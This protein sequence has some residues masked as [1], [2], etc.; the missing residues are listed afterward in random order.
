MY[1]AYRICLF[2]FLFSSPLDLLLTGKGG[3]GG[4]RVTAR[5]TVPGA[6]SVPANE[7]PEA[8]VEAAARGAVDTA[9]DDV[10]LEVDA[11][12]ASAAVKST[13][14]AVPK[15]VNPVPGKASSNG[16][17]RTLAPA[18]EP[19]AV[20]MNSDT[21]TQAIVPVTAFPNGS[22]GGMDVIGVHDYGTMEP[23]PF[24]SPRPSA[25][26]SLSVGSSQSTSKGRRTTAP[27]TAPGAVHATAE[28]PDCDSEI[29]T[30]SRSV[31]SSASTQMTSKGRRGTAPATAPGAVHA[32]AE[33]P[34]R[35][36]EQPRSSSEI[37][38]PQSGKSRRTTAQA[39]LI[40][41][42]VAV[43]NV[44]QQS[45]IDTTDAQNVSQQAK[46]RR[47]GSSDW[48]E[49]AAPLD[50]PR[51][52]PTDSP[53]AAVTAAMLQETRAYE[54][55]LP[56]GAAG[57]EGMDKA[58]TEMTSQD[59]AA[60]GR[61]SYSAALSIPGAHSMVATHQDSSNSVA[62][63][64]DPR[65][66]HDAHRP[67]GDSSKSRMSPRA[68]KV[69]E[70]EKQA[71]SMTG[72]EGSQPAN[73]SIP[74]SGTGEVEKKSLGES[75]VN[76]FDSEWSGDSISSHFGGVGVM[77]HTPVVPLDDVKDPYD[78]PYKSAMDEEQPSLDRMSNHAAAVA[79]ALTTES[80]GIGVA[81]DVA[82]GTTGGDSNDDGLAVAVAIPENDEERFL[83]AAVEYDPDSKP[84]LLKNRRFRLYAIS[85]IMLVFVIIITVILGVVVFKKKPGY[86]SSDAPSLAPTSTLDS[87]Y[88]QQFAKDLG[89]QDWTFAS[90]SPQGRAAQ[91][92]I[93]NDERNLGLEDAALTQRFLLALF[94]FSTT[95]NGQQPWRSCNPH[96]SDSAVTACDYER[97]TINDDD[98]VSY[99]PESSNR[100]LSKE[101]ECSWAGVLCDYV[102]AIIGVELSKCFAGL[103]TLRK[104][105]SY[106]TQSF[107]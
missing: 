89:Y 58:S 35:E 29:P 91:W 71:S 67:G 6:V 102:N 17:H 64:K 96:P 101:A 106:L 45:A 51:R 57:T 33:E 62:L 38:V 76:V 52:R 56:P 43:A 9:S 77:S 75:G 90:D 18:T 20:S 14:T 54:P 103:S 100:W 8:A 92:I 32:T 36:R 13:S 19:G 40:P 60:K 46:S 99:I 1:H 69:A 2:V 98:T 25:T 22:N 82:Y 10:S 47:L 68:E 27:A 105:A 11:T 30:S 74:P 31:A 73:H 72:A 81:P 28:E 93:D 5:A 95:Q 24:M 23:E 42:A 107:C 3:K 4:G 15:P 83:P 39:A 21:G 48:S 80:R 26:S 84:P 104:E 53:P 44:E 65:A 79:A 94:Y 87:Q 88:F 50:A 66:R 61:S 16:K 78:D 41:G 34:D 55:P 12:Q 70:A 59:S 97:Y 37:L 63:S 85:G 7:E 49:G 86:G